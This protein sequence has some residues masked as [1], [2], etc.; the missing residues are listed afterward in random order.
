MLTFVHSFDDQP[1]GKILAHL[2][3][4]R[5]YFQQ[6]AFVALLDQGLLAKDLFRR[7]A[8]KL[9]IEDKFGISLEN[10]AGGFQAQLILKKVYRDKPH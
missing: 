7:K 8:T 4:Q 10:S 1:Y 2:T 3:Y 9:V 5:R 6:P